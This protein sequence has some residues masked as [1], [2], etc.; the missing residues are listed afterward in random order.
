MQRLLEKFRELFQLLDEF[1]PR[2]MNIFIARHGETCGRNVNHMAKSSIEAV[3][4]D[5]TDSGSMK[6]R[7]RAHFQHH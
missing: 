7:S 5:L 1:H 3:R 2:A 6:V 4:F